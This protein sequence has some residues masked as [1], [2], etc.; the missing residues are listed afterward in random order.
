MFYV[1]KIRSK[2][3]KEISKLLEKIYTREGQWPH[4]LSVDSGKEWLNS[5]CMS[6]LA[7]NRTKLV[8]SK[9]PYKSM[10]SESGIRTIRAL[11]RRMLASKH[12]SSFWPKNVEKCIEMI[13]S[14]ISR[15][16]G[17]APKD[18]KPENTGE[19][20]RK[21]YPAMANL[22]LPPLKPLFA[23]GDSVRLIQPVQNIFQKGSSRLPSKEI[24]KIAR[25]IFNPFEIEYKLKA[26]SGDL[27]LGK[28][29][30]ESL[31]RVR[32]P[33]EDFS[34]AS[35]TSALDDSGSENVPE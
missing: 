23:V 14:R 7:K 27:V 25:I 13:N 2:E 31:V 3:G 6:L 24:Y 4:L 11:M 5:H 10:V 19:I 22:S 33:L 34:N 1:E 18:V 9:S 17:F 35:S 32:P 15:Q 26:S 20:F 30:N 29:T 28:Y 8:L 16:T 21:M 12:F